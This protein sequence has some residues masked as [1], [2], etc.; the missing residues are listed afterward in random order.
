M[1][2][3]WFEQQRGRS[4]GKLFRMRTLC[5]YTVNQ[6]FRQL[7]AFQTYYSVSAKMAQ[8]LGLQDASSLELY[9]DYEK[10]RRRTTWAGVLQLHSIYSRRMF[11]SIALT[12]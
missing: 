1:L 4:T 8:D 9:N 2:I 10:S 11:P 12:S 7:A 5:Y 3:S 6:R